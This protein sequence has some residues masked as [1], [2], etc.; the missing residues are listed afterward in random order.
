M[1]KTSKGNIKKYI[2]EIIRV[3]P[4]EEFR[5][6]QGYSKEGTAKYAETVGKGIVE[7]AKNQRTMYDVNSSFT[8]EEY[9]SEIGIPSSTWDDWI[10]RYPELKASAKE[11]IMLL[12]I[13]R[14][15]AALNR[16]VDA[17]TMQKVQWHYSKIWKESAEFHA[18]LTKTDNSNSAPEFVVYNADQL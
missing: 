3:L 15:A 18:S 2:K 5:Y 6:L 7:W 10:A 8:L 11:A 16:R 1:K 12:G 4:Y 9:Y 17:S 13:A 14:E